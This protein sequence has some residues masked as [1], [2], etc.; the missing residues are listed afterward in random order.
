MAAVLAMTLAVTVVLSA[1]AYGVGLMMSVRS[2]AVRERVATRLGLRRPP[3]P[4]GRPIEAI[5]ADLHRLAGRFHSLDPHASYVKV[6]AVRSAY[7]RSLAEC[8][9][10]LGV[11]HLLDVLSS[12]PE[13]DAERQRVEEQLAGCGVRIPDVA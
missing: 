2:E 8:C 4:A 6:E 11:D 13:L 12:G 7:D 10:A 9:A 1:L 3:Q 5:S